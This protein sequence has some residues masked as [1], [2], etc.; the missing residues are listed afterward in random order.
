M[1]DQ[2]AR[3][4]AIRLWQEGCRRLGAGDVD[5]AITLYT[6]S[7]EAHPTAEGYTFRGWAMSFQ[8]QLDEAIAECLRAIEVDPTF[9]NPYNDI[10]CY[11]MQQGQLD[12]AL[13]WLERA[14]QA[15]RYESPQ[16]PYLNAGRVYIAKE[17]YSAALKEFER[18]LELNPDDRMARAAV[19]ALRTNIN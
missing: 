6:R 7:I 3:T 2:Q 17:M 5:G 16:F 15:P 8:G 9:G 4:E 11:L 1:N 18:A 14:K 19:Q 13:V 12:E 10:G